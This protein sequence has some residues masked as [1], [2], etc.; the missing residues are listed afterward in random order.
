VAKTVALIA[1]PLYSSTGCLFLVC[2]LIFVF[3]TFIVV[4]TAVDPADL[5][6]WKMAQ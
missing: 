5:M 2:N 4:V 1:V 3:D 6:Y